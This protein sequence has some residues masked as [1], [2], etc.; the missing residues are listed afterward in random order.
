MRWE[1]K[2]CA[3]GRGRETQSEELG[4]RGAGGGGPAGAA[5]ADRRLAGGHIDGHT[6]LGRLGL[7]SFGHCQRGN[8]ARCGAIRW[9]AAFLDLRGDVSDPHVLY[10]TAVRAITSLQSSGSC[11]PPASRTGIRQM[12]GGEGAENRFVPFCPELP[13]AV[14]LTSCA[15]GTLGDA[16]SLEHLS[17]DSSRRR[18][19]VVNE[20]TTANCSFDS[21][22][23]WRAAAL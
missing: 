6:V 20:R 19:S 5:C 14:I 12:E 23:D 8:V 13:I 11:A 3:G 21:A 17:W 4:G 10:G 2:A 1:A 16:A 7:D 18:E 22:G 9:R 15:D